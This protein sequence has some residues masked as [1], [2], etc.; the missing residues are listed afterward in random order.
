MH[1]SFNFCI[2][3]WIT[4]HLIWPTTVLHNNLTAWLNLMPSKMRC[5]YNMCLMMLLCIRCTG[6]RPLYCRTFPTITFLISY[7][8]CNLLLFCH[9]H[10][11]R[12]HCEQELE[13]TRQQLLHV[14]Q[15][16]VD[17]APQTPAGEEG[18]SWPPGV[19]P[20]SRQLSRH[21]VLKWEYFTDTYIYMHSEL[22]NRKPLEGSD[23]KL[24]IGI[25]KYLI[26]V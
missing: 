5:P 6:M 11:D 17:L 18:L 13:K 4:T 12:H 26:G 21:D 25:F 14:Q 23:A 3:G 1:Y 10:A 16:L 2:R 15:Q 22:S 19:E 9:A 20:P 24:R 7:L 8:S